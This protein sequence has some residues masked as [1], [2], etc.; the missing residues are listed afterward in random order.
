MVC[1]DAMAARRVIAREAAE[2]NEGVVPARE[3][4]FMRSL[5]KRLQ[6][7]DWNSRIDAARFFSPVS[8]AVSPA[9]RRAVIPR[10]GV[11]SMS[12]DDMWAGQ[13]TM[14]RIARPVD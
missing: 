3:N 13:S 11:H 8:F 14:E 1:Y 2:V 6:D 12:A 9:A 4:S 10:E 7:G 5:L